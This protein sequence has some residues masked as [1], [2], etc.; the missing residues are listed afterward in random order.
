MSQQIVYPFGSQEIALTATQSIAVRV[1]GSDT[2]TI[3]RQVGF[4]N[5]PSSF[6]RLAVL[7]DQEQVYGPFTGGTVVRIDAGADPVY[8]NVAA[9]PLGAI[10]FKAPIADPSFFGYAT[11]FIEYDS[12]TWTIT[13][14]FVCV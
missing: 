2:A 14:Q 7:S 9:A 5:Y 1:S 8:F 12:N 4:P 13:A 10:T 11:D 3:S 6:S